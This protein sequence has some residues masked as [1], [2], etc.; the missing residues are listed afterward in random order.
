MLA[1]L[2]THP[3]YGNAKK[4]FHLITVDW[5][6]VWEMLAKFQCE[7]EARKK[8]KPKLTIM[9][10]Q[11]KIDQKQQQTRWWFQKYSPYII[12]TFTRFYQQY[13]A[14]SGLTG[15]CRQYCVLV[16]R[17][18]HTE[19]HSDYTCRTLSISLWPFVELRRIHRM[20][21]KSL[22]LFIQLPVPTINVDQLLRHLENKNQDCVTQPKNV[23]AE[24]FCGMG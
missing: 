6:K 18:I 5:R 4:A 10:Q 3:C 8:K 17:F 1:L 19:F 15:Q 16:A 12:L 14:G 13:V 23:R 2:N 9:V 11:L 7:P 22:M 21:Y 20:R 24:V